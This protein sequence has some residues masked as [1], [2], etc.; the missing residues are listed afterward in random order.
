MGS[1]RVG[2]D[3]ETFTFHFLWHYSI[4]RKCWRL[5]QNTVWTNKQFQWI[6]RVQINVE[7]SIVF[8]HNKNKLSER[9][10]KETIS[11]PNALKRIKYL[12]K[13]L[14]KEVKDQHTLKLIRHCWRKLQMTHISG[15]IFHVHG[16]EESIL[17]KGLYRLNAVLSKLR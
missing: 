1:Q 8:L 14:A 3:W 6:C 4:Y 17:L 13:N 5:H 2:H 10:I 7:K 16:L 12:W 9:K 11:F 15:K